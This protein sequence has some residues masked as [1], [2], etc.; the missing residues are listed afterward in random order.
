MPTLPAGRP[1][2]VAP[3]L[4]LAGILVWTACGGG[5]KSPTGPSDPGTPAPTASSITLS[6]DSLYFGG[7]GIARSI[8]ATAKTSE[9]AVVAGASITWADRGHHRRGGIARRAARPALAA[10]LGQR[11]QST[12]KPAICSAL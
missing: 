7:I 11:S 8:S 9:G 2:L 3:V 4:V 10:A 6:L 1:R 5:D 12:A